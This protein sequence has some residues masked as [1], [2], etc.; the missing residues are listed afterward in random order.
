MVVGSDSKVKIRKLR[1]GD[2]KKAGQFRERNI[3][4]MWK[5]YLM[6]V[7]PKEAYAFEVWHWSEASLMERLKDPEFF[8][9]MA[10]CEGEIC[11]I[12]AG[13]VYGKSGFAMVNWIAVAPEH[14]H[15]GIGIKLMS[16]MEEHVA[17]RGCHKVSLHTLPALVPAVRLYMKFGLLPE[18]FLRQQWWGADFIL[19]SKW[20]G[21]YRK[22]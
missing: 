5:N 9:I 21:K 2:A 18:A 17:K 8:G 14:Q 12:L 1:K 22:H 10:E 19:M 16:A 7:Y 13:M 4:W 20:I 6:G 3:A 15:E 11:G